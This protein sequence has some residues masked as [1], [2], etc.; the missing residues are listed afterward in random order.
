MSA[1]FRRLDGIH[2][3]GAAGP[4]GVPD[5]VDPGFEMAGDHESVWPFPCGN[6]CGQV[7]TGQSRVVGAAE[8]AWAHPRPLRR[9]HNGRDFS[10]FAR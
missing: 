5:T 10:S 1:V 8:N 3:R 6:F 9:A 7:F 2:E 4:H